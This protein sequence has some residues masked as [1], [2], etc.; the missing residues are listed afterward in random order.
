MFLLGAH[1]FLFFWRR[2]VITLI[3]KK[4]FFRLKMVH[5]FM[6]QNG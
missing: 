4:I 1:M 2:K 5:V 3:K 6:I